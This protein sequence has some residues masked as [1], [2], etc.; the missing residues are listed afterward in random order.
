MKTKPIKIEFLF[1]IGQEVRNPFGYRGIVKGQ[2][3]DQGGISYFVQT[4]HGDNW[5][6]EK[7]L[8]PF[9]E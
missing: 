8:L 7:Q 9:E 5:F 2:Y 6:Y 4:M 3:V 1:R